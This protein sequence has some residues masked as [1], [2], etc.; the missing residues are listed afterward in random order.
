MSCSS[1]PIKSSFARVGRNLKQASASF[2]R[3]SRSSRKINLS[4][5]RCRYSTSDAAYSSCSGESVS[6]AQ[7]D[8]CCCLEMLT[9]SSSLQI[10]HGY[11]D[12]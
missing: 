4:R 3:P 11:D 6:A 5:S 2:V 12:E 10:L 8:D 1:Q 7:S 9:P